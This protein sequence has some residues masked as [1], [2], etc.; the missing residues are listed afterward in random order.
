MEIEV[1]QCYCRRNPLW[2]R[3]V[4]RVNRQIQ[5]SVLDFERFDVTI[6]KTTEGLELLEHQ[7]LP[8]TI[9]ANTGYEPVPEELF[10]KLF[11]M[12][13]IARAA[14]QAKCQMPETY[15]PSLK[16]DQQ[17]LSPGRGHREQERVENLLREYGIIDDTP[18]EIFAQQYAQGMKNLLDGVY[19]VV[20]VHK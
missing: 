20:D 12:A 18:A 7:T 3:D 19:D 4:V 15:T 14:S 13:R 1:G 6:I 16:R 9:F 2:G 11:A 10:L 8:L 17:E 5:S